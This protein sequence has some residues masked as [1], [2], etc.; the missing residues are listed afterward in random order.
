MAQALRSEGLDVDVRSAHGL[1]ADAPD[2]SAYDAVIVGGALY[3]NRWHKDARRFVRTHAQELRTRPVWLFSSG[4]LDDSAQQR[5]IA[6]VSQV[7]IAM[8][9]VDARG[10]ATFGGRLAPDAKGFPASAMAKKNAGDWRDDQ[11]VRAWAHS[12]V[13]ALRGGEGPEADGVEAPV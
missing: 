13:T 2:I 11:Q 10:H 4:P 9:E 12:V 6:P 8:R 7:S 1:G 3:A 5:D